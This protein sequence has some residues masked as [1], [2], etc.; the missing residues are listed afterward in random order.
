MMAYTTHPTSPRASAD[1]G[2]SLSLV[3]VRLC[4]SALVSAALAAGLSSPLAGQTIAITGGTVYPVSGP[5]IENATVLIRDGRFVAVGTNVQV[6]AGAQQ[7]D[8]RGKWVTPGLIDVATQI[9]LTEIGAV[10]GT[11]EGTLAGNDVSASFNVLEGINPASQLIPVARIEG[12]TTVM[13]S[14]GGG[15]ISGQAVALDLWGDR[16]EDMVIK[17]PVA[18]VGQINEGAKGT[19]GGSRAGVMARLRR[20]FNDAR[21]YQ[22]RRADYQR[23]QMPDLSAPVADL[24]A[25]LPVLRGELPIVLAANRRSDI[26]NALRLARE[27]TLKLVID[28]AVEGWQVADQLATARVPVI[29]NPLTDIPSYDGLSPKLENAALLS[30][31]GVQVIIASF[32]SHNSRNIKQLAGNA[33][34]YGVEWDAAL[35][36]VTLAPA[37]AL[38]IGDRYG[39]LEGGKVA[40]VAVW[41]GDPFEFSSAAENVFIRGME[42]PLTSRQRDL[43]R[44]YKSLPP[45]YQ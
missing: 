30:R 12:I 28:G 38:G 32:D 33:V 39:S 2:L 25:L 5:R 23:R 1:G 13:S 26:E 24:E 20:L 3:W 42:V 43:L 4:S 6:P 10:Q 29:I 17:S 21:E 16:I 14:P 9:G 40:D 8:A 37:L 19:G 7:V 22:R 44:R 45:K 31:A 18:V 35:R 34:T 27:Y 36:A 11:N 15:L 41:S